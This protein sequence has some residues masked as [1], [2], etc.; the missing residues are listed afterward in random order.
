M[1]IAILGFGAEGQSAFS[2]WNTEGNEITICDSDEHALLPEGVSSRLGADYLSGLDSFDLIVRSPGLYPGDIVASN[3][4]EILSKVTS[5]T[6]EFFK[7]SPTKN[8][9]GVTGTK[10]KGTTSTLITRL[11][12]A[13]GHRVHLG[14]NIGKPALTLLKD[15]ISPDDWVVLELSSFQLVDLN[16]SPHIAVCLMI[17]PEHLNWHVDMDEYIRAKTNIFSHQLSTDIAIYYGENKYS[18]DLSNASPGEKIPYF[19]LPGAVVKDGSFVIDGQEVC[20]VADIKLLGEHNW[21][22][23]CAALTVYWQIDKNIELAKSVITNF[24][25]LEHRLEPVAEKDSIKY[26]N[27]SFASVPDATIA[28]IQAIPGSKVLIIGGYDR[29]LELLNLAST[30]KKNE[31]TIERVLLIGES[32]ERVA[33][34]LNKIEFSNFQITNAETMKAIVELAKSIAKP[35]ESVILSPGFPSFDMFKN[36]ED[37]GNQFKEAVNNL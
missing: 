33:D 14:G 11:L 12:E 1:K 23:I 13:A 19:T 3:S 28:A 34:V 27:D 36:F 25:G 16:Y 5:S 17:V 37:R 10:G 22:N 35:G 21:Q 7:I 8:I 32:S 30:I 26:Y 4:P 9:I 18:S 15:K 29:Q 6:N 31:T 20:S 2:Y 24:S